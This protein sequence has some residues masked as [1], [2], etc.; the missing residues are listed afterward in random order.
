MPIMVNDIFN[1]DQ[2]VGHITILIY[3]KNKFL[4][5]EK[6]G[7]IIDDGEKTFR[8][9]LMMRIQSGTGGGMLCNKTQQETCTV[10][11]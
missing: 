11:D 7:S 9:F 4:K 5:K 6:A 2:P 3:V 8:T 1:Q 10:I